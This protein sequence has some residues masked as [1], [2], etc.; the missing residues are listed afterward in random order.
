MSL[1]LELAQNG[2]FSAVNPLFWKPALIVVKMPHFQ[3]DGFTFFCCQTLRFC[4]RFNEVCP[5]VHR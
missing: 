1:R 3:V 4:I 2:I 5:F